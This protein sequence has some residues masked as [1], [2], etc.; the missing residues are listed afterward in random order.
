MKTLHFQ[1]TMKCAGCVA[2]VSPKLEGIR[3]LNKWQALVDQPNPDYNFTADVDSDEVS[4]DIMDAF[5][6]AGYEARPV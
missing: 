1:T 4:K 5:Q 3:G 2:A 6:K